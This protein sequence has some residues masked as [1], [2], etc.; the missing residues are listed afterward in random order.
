MERLRLGYHQVAN[1][2]HHLMLHRRYA[3]MVFVRHRPTLG[4]NSTSQVAKYSGGPPRPSR[5]MVKNPRIS[6]ALGD[7]PNTGPL[8]NGVSR[9][10]NI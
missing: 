10:C 9:I 8:E 7:S 4:A 3:E 1:P 5:R 6:P 2:R